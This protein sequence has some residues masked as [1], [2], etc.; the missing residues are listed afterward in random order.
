MRAVLRVRTWGGLVLSLLLGASYEAM[1][2]IALLPHLWGFVT[3]SAVSY[4]TD[5]WL[6]RL[7]PSFIRRMAAFRMDRTMRFLARD[8]LLL[9]LAERMDAP[10]PMLVSGLLVLGGQFG[11]LVLYAALHRVIRRTRTL[12]VA[13]RN[14][15]MGDAG[16]PKAPPA[17][18]YRRYLRRL[19]H[20][21]LP[22]HAGLLAGLAGANWAVTK[23][24][25]ALS[26]VLPA[27]ALLALSGQLRRARRMPQRDEIIAAVNRQ[28]ATYR[29]EV[30][31]YFNFAAVSR[32]F[33]YQ[34]NMWI[35]ILE[36]LDR[37]PLIILR[38][39]AS[40][41]YLSRTRLP[42]LCVPKADDV[43]EL[44]LPDLKIGALPGQRGQER[45]HAA[46]SRGQARLHRPRRQR[47]ARQ[48]Q[49]GQQ[50]LR[51]DLGRRARRT[52]PLPAH[53]ARH[54]RHR[55]R[56]GRPPPAGPDPSARPPRTR[57][58]ADGV[59]RADLGR[60]ER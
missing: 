10:E 8:A 28:L 54:R 11:V 43:A 30:V 33:M 12:P 56:G 50:G 42:V 39:R 17:L 35:E 34:V 31:L 21:D 3:A 24:G 40:F 29:P 2:L 27:L 58:A 32:D 25:Y 5:A 38:E 19:L 57:P 44:D 46:R 4:V 37:R 53:P 41:R 20:L 51:R 47:Q 23:A 7:E 48:Q 22:M 14:L 16:I 49:P 45:P 52:R 15:D 36:N 13:V 59:V 26:L 9:V 55:D 60:L 1:P 6:H 18:L